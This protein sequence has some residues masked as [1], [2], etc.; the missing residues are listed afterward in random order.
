MGGFAVRGNDRG[1]ALLLVITLVLMLSAIGAA[2][3]IASRTETMI[4]A[5]F[6]QQR[7]TLYAAEGAVAQAVHDVASSPD[8]SPVLTGSAVSSFTDGAA[9]GP[10]RLPG[11]DTVTL[12]CG[13]LSLTSSVQDRALGGRSWGADTPV[14]QLFAWGPAADW[15]PAGRIDSA[16]YVVVW[17]ADDPDDGDGDP[18]VDANGVMLLHGQALGPLGGRQVIDA[19]IRRGSPPPAP[20]RIMSW[21]E[22]QW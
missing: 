14:W 5:N 21:R 1:T 10:R 19:L 2:V 7:E 9:T 4:A 6:R 3:S 13:P 8:W 11:G 15:L 12:C 20:V 22:G 18:G 17:V 16:L